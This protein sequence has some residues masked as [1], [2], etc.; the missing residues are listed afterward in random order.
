M[1]QVLRVRYL[2]LRAYRPIWQ[3]MRAFTDNRGDGDDD[4]LW[5]VQHPPVFTQGQAGKPEHLLNASA[6]PVV[7]T[8]RGGQITYH[9]PGQVI[10]Y[11]LINL[12]RRQLSVRDMVTLLEATAVELLA[13][14]NI[15]AYTKTGAPGVY[16]QHRGQEAKIAFLGLRVRKGCTFHGLSINVAMDLAPFRQINPC[17]YPG[18]MVTQLSALSQVRDLNYHQVEQT[19]A[20]LITKKLA[21]PINQANCENNDERNYA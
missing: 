11:P 4:Q 21:L 15:S 1:A 19:V 9:G 6:I 17:G 14:Y 5:L 3:A 12:R 16:L 8:D 7:R 13:G 18:L 20:Q 10:A 2:G